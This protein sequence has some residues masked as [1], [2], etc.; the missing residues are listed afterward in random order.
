M[1]RPDSIRRTLRNRSGNRDGFTLIEVIVVLLVISVLAAT[2]APALVRPAPQV[3]AMEEAVNR[4]E[5]LFSQARDAAVRSARA[6]AVVLDSITGLAW[7][8]APGQTSSETP[9]MATG[10]EASAGTGTPALFGNTFGSGST[11]GQEHGIPG[12]D[13]RVPAGAVSFDLPDGIDIV[14]LMPRTRFTFA[15]AGSAVG[16]SL[17]LVS[18]TG[19]TCQITVDPWNGNVRVR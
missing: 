17:R 6:V 19:Q 9:S 11:L 10:P 12:A 16:D 8:D 3:T 18:R 1:S 2:V 13:E 4:F 7:I 14:Y 15:P 5:T